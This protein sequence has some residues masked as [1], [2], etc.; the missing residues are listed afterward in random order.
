MLK[1]AYWALHAEEVLTGE[2]K[3]PPEQY[4]RSHNRRFL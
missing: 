4:L 2:V 3:N 1:D